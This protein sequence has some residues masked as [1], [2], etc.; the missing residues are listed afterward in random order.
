MKNP[1]SSFLEARTL[2]RKISAT[3]L[4]YEKLL[5]YNNAINNIL[6]TYAPR[7]EIVFKNRGVTSIFGKVLDESVRD[8]RHVCSGRHFGAPTTEMACCADTLINVASKNVEKS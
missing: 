1:A 7:Q 5:S 4:P 8:N 3:G 2:Q 6:M